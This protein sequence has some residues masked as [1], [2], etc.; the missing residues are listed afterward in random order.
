MEEG[1][2]VVDPCDLST[3]EVEAGGLKFILSYTELHAPSS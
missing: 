2:V 1:G 3:R